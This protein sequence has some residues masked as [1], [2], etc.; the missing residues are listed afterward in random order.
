MFNE[1]YRM[2]TLFYFN[3][4]TKFNYE[5]ATKKDFVNPDIIIELPWRGIDI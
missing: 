2:V 5:Y 1:D 4:R 3:N